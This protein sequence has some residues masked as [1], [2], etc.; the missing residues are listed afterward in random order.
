MLSKSD[1]RLH[2]ELQ[3]FVVSLLKLNYQSNPLGLLQL[4]LYILVLFVLMYFLE[5]EVAA[6]LVFVQN[7]LVDNVVY[8]LWG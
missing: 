1:T 3:H 7:T 6:F 5:Y 4:A 8:A 2:L